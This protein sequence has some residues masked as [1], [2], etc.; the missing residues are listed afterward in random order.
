MD[1][2]KSRLIVTAVLFSLVI[3]LS[4][5]GGKDEEV[6]PPLELPEDAESLVMLAKFDLALRTGV[7]LEQILTESLEETLFDDSSL[8]VPQPGAVY[9]AIV[10]PGYIIMLNAGGE[11]YE[12]HASGAKVVHVPK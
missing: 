11:S 5:C 9:E 10:T 3:L 8:G 4:A 6:G 1:R 2:S 12:Y 7:D